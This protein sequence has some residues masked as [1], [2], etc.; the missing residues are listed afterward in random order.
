MYDVSMG[1]V[2]IVGESVILLGSCWGS[3]GKSRGGKFSCQLSLCIS[4]DV[5]E[6]FDSGCWPGLL[7]SVVWSWGITGV[8]FGKTVSPRIVKSGEL[9]PLELLFDKG[10]KFKVGEE[11]VI[12]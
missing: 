8:I 10:L 12:P 1:C 6:S 3:W 9:E 7:I 11:S 2:V 5:D 4:V